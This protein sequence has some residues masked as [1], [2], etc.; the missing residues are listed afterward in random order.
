VRTGDAVYNEDESNSIN[1]YETLNEGVVNIT[2]ETL[3]A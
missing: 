2:T 1:V 3:A